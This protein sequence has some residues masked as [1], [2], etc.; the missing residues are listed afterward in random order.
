MNFTP[1]PHQHD[2]GVDDKL[3]HCIHFILGLLQ[4]HWREGRADP[5]PFFLGVNG[6]QGVGKTTLVSAIAA[7]LRSPPHSLPTVVL[8]ID[9]LYL[10]HAA[11]T[12]L[13]SSHP[14][15]ALIQHRGEPGTHD[16][17]L[18]LSLFNALKAHQ[19]AKIPAYDKSAHNGQG[20]RVDASTWEEVNAPGSLEKVQ[21]VIFEG[22]CVGFRAL[23]SRELRQ[24]WEEA[25]ES[26][27]GTLWKHRLEDLEFV[28]DKLRDYD[29]LTE[30]AFASLKG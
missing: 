14:L 5:P 30:C 9:D 3:A 1:P 15:N 11:Q 18:G 28:N 23:G 25:L 8:S 13:A 27:E 19:H 4:A 7:T 17:A 12:L 26:R 24:K 16:I 10:P 29:A 22:W 21:V 6:V 20:D 2:A